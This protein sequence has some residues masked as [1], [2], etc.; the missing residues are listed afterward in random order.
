MF[1]YS[2]QIAFNSKKL[3]EDFQHWLKNEHLRHVCEAGALHADLVQW[4]DVR[5]LEAR[6]FFASE[7]AFHDYEQN[8]APRLRAEALQRIP[9]GEQ[10]EF[11]RR[12]GEWL[13]S[14]P[15]T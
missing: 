11:T 14:Y 15:S 8:H 6:Y 4:T 10:V 1:V 13:S 5:Q 12:T 3:A 2:V 9:T 7:R